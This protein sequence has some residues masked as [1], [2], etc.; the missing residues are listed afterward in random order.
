MSWVTLIWALA[1][2]ACLAMA[3]PFLFVGISQRRAA[4]LFFVTAVTATVAIAAAEFAMMRSDSV[5]QFA[6]ALR[7]VQLPIFVLVVSIVGF[8]RLYFGTGRLWL[9]IATCAVRFV[10]LIIDFLSPVN[11]NFREITELQHLRFLGETVSTPVGVLSPWTHVAELSSLLLLLFVVDATISLWLQRK[12]SSRRR[13]LIVGG[14]IMFFIVLAAGVTALIHLKIIQAPYLVSFPFVAIIV[15]MALELGYDLFAAT[16]VAKKLQLSEASLYESE[17]RFRI[18]ANAAPVMI[19]MS[20]VD[21]LCTF[22]NN[23]WLEFTGRAMEQELRNGW[24]DGVHADDLQK[25]FKTYTEAFD[26]R[27]PFV[28]QYRLRR[29]DGEYRWV[30]DQGVPRYDAQRD[31]AG[32]IGSCI[33]VTELVNKDVALRESEERM[34]LAADAVNLG[35]WEWDLNKDEIWATT[36][37]RALLGWPA[38]GKIT[39]E[40][41]ISTVHPDDRN[42]IR[43]AING[44]IHKG[45]HYDSE[46]RLV[47]PDGIVRWMA[48]RGSVR[49]DAHG[50]PARLLGISI[51]ITARK[52]A[53]LEAKQRRDELSHL[54]RVA[55]VGE[56][57]ASIAHELN[58]PLAGIQTNAGAGE[59]LIDQGGVDLKEIRQLLADIGADA[60]RASDIVR[61]IRGM[62]K[63]E[64][65][66]RCRINLN[67]V[68]TSVVQII[69]FD[70]LLH[71]CELKTSL[72]AALPMVEAD[73]VQIQQVLINLIVNAFDAMCDTPVSKRRVEIMTQRSGDGCVRISVRDYG[74]GISEEVRSRLFEQFFTTKPEG[75]GMGLAIVRSIIEA[76]AGT[77]EA[78]NAEREGA[79]FHFTLPRSADG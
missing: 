64:Q 24:T 49:F 35:I 13:A 26:A 2:G 58:Q 14:S 42:R 37:R 77:I 68:V 36:A 41:F 69:R 54:S 62:I 75:L 33:D 61:G 30:S 53:E 76:H 70:A 20:G 79:R 45:Q 38:S 56:L 15:A 19:W 59:F 43:Q 67:D 55:L 47:L 29:N 5:E 66:T 50:N 32:Y 63:K 51:D 78:E 71:A 34:R 7:W 3:L 40:D 31:F 21:K 18:M 72:E 52:R 11:L 16:Q 25:C 8:V 65:V 6:T 4:P 12:S 9:G 46:Y 60:R 39:L 73:P 28:M 57:S 44:A 27:Q 48:A 22:F 17:A 23:P 74:V 10:C 1:M